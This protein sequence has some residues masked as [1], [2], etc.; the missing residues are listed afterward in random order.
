MYN[1]NFFELRPNK[2]VEKYKICI[3]KLSIKNNGNKK[4][5]L[6]NRKYLHPTKPLLC[7]SMCKVLYHNDTIKIF[8]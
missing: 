4:N 2:I 3:D 7:F 1:Q 6:I 8:S 5:L